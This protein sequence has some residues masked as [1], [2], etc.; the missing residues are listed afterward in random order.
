MKLVNCVLLVNGG[1][2]SKEAA[3]ETPYY[4]ILPYGNGYVL[5]GELQ[6]I[7]APFASAAVDSGTQQ[8]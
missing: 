8:Q 1:G 5:S 6:K 7:C 2:N 4:H 3:L